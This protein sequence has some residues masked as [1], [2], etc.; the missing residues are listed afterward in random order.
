MLYLFLEARAEN[1]I[2]ALVIKY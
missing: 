1:N 2:V